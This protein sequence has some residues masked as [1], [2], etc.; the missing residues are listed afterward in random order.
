MQRIPRVTRLF[1]RVGIR[2]VIVAGGVEVVDLLIEEV[3]L[4]TG[5]VWA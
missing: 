5:G 3:S 4:G 2:V 1:L